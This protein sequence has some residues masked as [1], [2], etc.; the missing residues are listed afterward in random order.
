[1]TDAF[2]LLGFQP[3]PWIDQDQLKSRFLN[4]SESH[5][6]DR[7][8]SSQNPTQV[9]A[10]QGYADLN[11]AFCILKSDRDRLALLWQLETGEKAPST[12]NIPENLTALFMEVG[13][14]CRDVALFN[15]ARQKLTAPIL[16]AQA[17]G[18]ALAWTQRLQ[19]IQTR[20][21][22]LGIVFKTDLIQ[23]DQQWI[24]LDVV[25]RREALRPLQFRASCLQRWQE[26]LREHI[27]QLAF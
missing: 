2:T 26:Q 5:H 10:D 27:S 4:L 11:V 6:P 21:C 14:T 13:Q 15:T 17:F 7:R 16:K 1:M 3:R 22:E 12:A 20:V 18:Q 9:G 8:R 25:A 19:E 24:S 23:I